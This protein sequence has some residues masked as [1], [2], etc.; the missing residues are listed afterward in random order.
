MDLGEEAG[1]LVI[2]SAKLIGSSRVEIVMVTA[3]SKYDM[4]D[5]TIDGYKQVLALFTEYLKQEL[6]IPK[7]VTVKGILKDNKG[8]ELSTVNI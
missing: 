8:R 3:K 1:N 7:S 4:A 6:S 2:Q 5:S